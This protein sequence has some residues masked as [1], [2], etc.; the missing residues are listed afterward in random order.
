MKVDVH[1]LK[2]LLK[3]TEGPK[4]DFKASLCL[5]QESNK[6]EFVKDVCA[7]ANSKGGRG[8]IVFGVKDKS[9]EVVGFETKDFEEERIQR[10]IC[11]R[12]DPPIPIR[13]DEIDYYG[14]NVMI[15]TIFKT[16]QAPHQLRKNG[17][18]YVRRGSTNDVARREEIANML[19]E[20]G[21]VSSELSVIHR[22]TLDELDLGL[23]K[24]KLNM[25]GDLTN[26]SNKMLLEGLGFIGS[27]EHKDETHPTM[28]GLLVFGKDP[29][30]FLP[31]AGIKIIH[32]EKEY[33][34]SGNILE[35]I[36]KC[37]EIVENI[38]KDSSYPKEAIRQGII[39]AIVHRDYWDT[40]RSIVVTI[41]DT[42]VM[43]SNPGAMRHYRK[44]RKM[45]KE[46]NP[47]RRNKW[48]YQ[49]LILIDNDRHIFKYSFGLR[50][51]KEIFENV[52]IINRPYQNTFKIILPG[53]KAHNFAKE[54]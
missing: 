37:D 5:D 17:T 22:A 4:L 14:K 8:Y 18:F 29:Q 1:K 27:F 52:N 34:I 7:I 47:P 6:K 28:G 24:E 3:R 51:I 33:E 40:E 13:V 48:L 19:Q 46:I 11:N 38:L 23:I 16:K 49:R 30:K 44:F 25:T 42:A 45:L 21:I 10:M 39:N 9:K 43:I 20:N 35:M 2:Q 26:K 41:S 53:I 32:G 54:N 15:L 12:C 50:K 36:N 31:H